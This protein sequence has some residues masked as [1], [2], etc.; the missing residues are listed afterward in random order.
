MHIAGII[1]EYNPFHT[2]H[3]HHIAATRALLGEDA[4]VVAVMSGNWV[5][6]GDCAVADKWSRAR[7]ALQGGADLVL[8]LPTPWALS[9]AEHFARGAAA[10]LAGSGAVDVLSFGSECG[11]TDRL[12]ALALCL[13]SPAFRE[14][15]RELLDLGLPFAVCRQRAAE[16][17]L[18]PEEAALLS[19]PNNNL[20]VEYLRALRALNSSIRPVTVPRR[21]ARHDGLPAEGF[22]SASLLRDWLRAGE[23]ERAA[24]YLPV[25]WSG[26]PAS[27]R[28]CERALLARVRALTAADW[29]A[30]PDSAPAEGLP[31][32]LERAGRRC[33]SMAEFFD[34]A[35]TKRFSHARL[36]RLALWAF[37]G[38]TAPDRPER[39]PYLRVLGFHSLRGREVLREIARRSS[40]PLLV[41]PAHV[42]R[43]SAEAQALFALEC[44]CTDLYGLCLP[45]PAPGALEWRTSPVAL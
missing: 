5:Q 15:L 4:A 36:R 38:L 40:L 37:L 41:K 42:R 20:G 28:W 30:L 45:D 22:S 24:P 12:L 3:A 17:L 32:R 18:G 8:E 25:P 39:P 16:A 31:R 1:A 43:L 13:D 14:R 44:R 6:R 19:R 7:S 10:L 34:L 2:G 9:T 11:D 26:E 23:R 27:L 29:A 33:A 21:G 35:K